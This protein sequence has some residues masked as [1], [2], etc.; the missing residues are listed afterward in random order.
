MGSV[1]ERK[2]HTIDSEG[3]IH[4][5]DIPATWDQADKMAGHRVDRRRSYLIADGKLR[6]LLRW[7]SS[8]S[9]CGG[10]GCRE[11]GYKGKSRHC[12]YGEYTGRI[13]T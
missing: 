1:I 11:C 13:T 6:F 2:G 8:C 10:S 3:F 4:Y 12:W 5:A 9:G 7:S